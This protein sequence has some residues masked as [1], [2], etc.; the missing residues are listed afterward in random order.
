MKYIELLFA[1]DILSKCYPRYNSHEL[2]LLAEDVFKWINNELPEDSSSLCYL[3]DCFESPAD[4]VKSIWNE[5]QLFSEPY[6][7]TN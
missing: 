1:L 6:L 3:K 4:A 7:H 5:I 2:F